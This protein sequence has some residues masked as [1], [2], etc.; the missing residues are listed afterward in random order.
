MRVVNVLGPKEEASL[1]E[2]KLEA[3]AELATVL[4]T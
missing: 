2:K 4:G 3:L 1:V